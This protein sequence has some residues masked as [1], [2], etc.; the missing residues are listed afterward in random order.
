MHLVSRLLEWVTTA[1][2]GRRAPGKHARVT[3]PPAAPL[4]V[5]RPRHSR[6][7]PPV[8]QPRAQW[9]P[10]HPWEDTGAMVRPYV[11]LLAGTPRTTRV[12]VHVDPWGDVR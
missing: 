6:H 12:G 10:P 1:L 3:S 11:T 5:A 9:F 7:T 2:V 4:V 8:P